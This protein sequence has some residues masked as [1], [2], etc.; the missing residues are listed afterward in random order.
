MACAQSWQRAATDLPRNPR[1]YC[2]L[3]ESPET[4]QSGATW[5]S[6]VL[7]PTQQHQR[8]RFDVA[9]STP[10]SLDGAASTTVRRCL[11]P[12]VWRVVTG[13]RER[14]VSAV[15]MPTRWRG[16][17]TQALRCRRMGLAPQ[18]PRQPR[19]RAR[20]GLDA[21]SPRGRASQAPFRRQHHVP[22]RVS[23]PRSCRLAP[24]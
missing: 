11:S 4:R 8:Q 1:T 24:C 3:S 9:T 22:T 6:R 12:G 15:V 16:A 7:R 10:G 19:V 18:R 2:W 13:D 5:C 23:A 20:L 21:L 17:R 14:H